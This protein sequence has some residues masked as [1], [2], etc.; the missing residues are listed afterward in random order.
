MQPCFCDVDKIQEIG[1]GL[2]GYEI[3]ELRTQ[4]IL[5]I[6]SLWMS[7]SIKTERF[8]DYHYGDFSYAPC[9]DSLELSEHP[10]M[11][12][13]VRSRENE[14]RLSQSILAGTQPDWQRC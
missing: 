4:Q 9:S 8:W 13:G 7:I 14:L 11:D 3:T 10:K 1:K 2:Q 5:A 12:Q 6:M